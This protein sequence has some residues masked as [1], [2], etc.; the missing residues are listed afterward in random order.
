MEKSQDNESSSFDSAHLPLEIFT[1]DSHEMLLSSLISLKYHVINNNDRKKPIEDFKHKKNIWE[2]FVENLTGLSKFRVRL[3]IGCVYYEGYLYEEALKCFDEAELLISNVQPNIN[4]EKILY[5]L[6]GD[7][8]TTLNKLEKGE[9]YLLKTEKLIKERFPDDF[10]YLITNK[11]NQALLYIRKEDLKK[12]KKYLKEVEKY[13]LQYR[14]PLLKMSL[15]YFHFSRLYEKSK[16]IS[17]AKT[18]L[19]KSL[20]Y[21]QKDKRLKFM[22]SRLKC[23]L[24]QMGQQ[25]FSEGIDKSKIE[26]AKAI[27]REGLRCFM[28]DLP[29]G[30]CLSAEA[31]KQYE[32]CFHM[33]CQVDEADPVID[34]DLDKFCESFFESLTEKEGL[35]KEEKKKSKK[36]R[37]LIEKDLKGENM[38]NDN[39]ISSDLSPIYGKKIEVSDLAYFKS[40]LVGIIE[41]SQENPR[42]AVEKV[43]EIEKK[44]EEA[45]EDKT[46][47][48]EIIP[49]DMINKIYLQLG[50]I[51]SH[52]S[53]DGEV[54]K[55][56]ERVEINTEPLQQNVRELIDFYHLQ[57][58]ISDN[59][60]EIES[61][62]KKIND[63]IEKFLAEKSI[64]KIRN[65]AL[66]G[67]LYLEQGVKLN[68]AG[69]CLI[70][71]WK[72]KQGGLEF[73]LRVCFYLVGLCL[74]KNKLKKAK[75]WLDRAQQL[76][77]NGISD[78]SYLRGIAQY[79]QT[80]I[81]FGQ[82]YGE[83]AAMRFKEVGKLLKNMIPQNSSL[84]QKLKLKHQIL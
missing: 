63:I 68:R 37:N 67:R 43:R 23:L 7:T 60:Q 71:V 47:L 50:M 13:S 62:I 72:T 78:Q 28:R 11:F 16:D 15:I 61:Y 1:F 75:I 40:D 53:I 44:L 35:I 38:S 65:L 12:A 70:K 54:K 58:T 83:Q 42:A 2:P 82:Q 45:L 51:Y 81:D 4:E 59:I 29:E 36:S 25:I 66:K 3:F 57:A 26:D 84:V 56:L 18:Y 32:S 69:K 9:E 22:E 6:K 74:K 20:E 79:Y 73:R 77:E 46:N 24:G 34:T 8:L 17:Q 21:I 64:F 76:M 5:N 10:G 39:L 48:N 52:A 31:M 49:A 30:N 19:R 55:R 80:E 27:F 33:K 41:L 14:K